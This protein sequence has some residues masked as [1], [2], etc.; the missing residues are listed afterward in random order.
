MSDLAVVPAAPVALLTVERARDMLA[1]S[2]QVDEVKQLGD[3]ANAMALYL[4]QSQAALGLQNDA[5]E[6][7]IW[8]RR[9]L[10]ELTS[11]IGKVKAGR[12]SA[13]LAATLPAK[14]EVLESLGLEP[15]EV[16]RC[17]ALAAVSEETLGQHIRGVRERSEKLTTS[18]AIAAVSHGGD[19][20]SNDWGTPAEYVELVR[21]VLGEID[22]DP[23]TS[24]H[25]QR[26]VK[27]RRYYT[28]ADDGLSKPWKGR[29]FLNPPYE[30]PACGHFIRRFIDEQKSGRLTKGILLLNAS[31]DTTWFHSLAARYQICFTNRRI[32]FLQPDGTPINGNRVGQIFVAA[33]CGREF[34]TE[35]EAAGIGLVLGR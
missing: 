9:R 10:G 6:I 23:A 4:R 34:K 13:D 26:I 16:R 32:G 11:K 3:Q 18:G 14:T 17:E 2:I 24:D 1:A 25:A 20:D 12:R 31:T 8:A 7:G 30:Q 5:T 19:Y 15:R 35:F 27:A 33:G 22:L 28:A 29:V 21:R